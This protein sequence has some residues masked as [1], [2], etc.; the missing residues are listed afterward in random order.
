MVVDGSGTAD[1]ISEIDEDPNIS[2]DY[3]PAD[4]LLKRL[5]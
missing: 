1:I 2:G 3:L 5:Y 4:R